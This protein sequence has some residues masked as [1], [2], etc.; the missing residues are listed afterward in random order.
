M[1]GRIIAIA[2]QKGGVGKT[3]VTAHLERIERQLNH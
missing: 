3:T 2:Q 1:P